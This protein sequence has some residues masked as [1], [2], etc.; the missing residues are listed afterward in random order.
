MLKLIRKLQVSWPGLA[1]AVVLGLGTLTIF[2]YLPSLVKVVGSPS[3]NI[4]PSQALVLGAQLATS[5]GG[6]L[7]PVS[8]DPA[9]IPFNVIQ[10]QTASLVAA[11]LAEAGLIEKPGLLKTYMRYKG[12]DVLIETGYFELSTTQ[13]IPEIALELTDAMPAEIRVRLWP[14]WRIE[15]IAAALSQRTYINVNAEVF[16]AYAQMATTQ[17]GKYAFVEYLPP[18]G[19]VE[20]LLRPD[21]YIFQPRATTI[22]VFEQLFTTADR[23]LEHLRQEA[24]GNGNSWYEILTLA[25]IVER[26]TIHDDEGALIAGVFLRRL[27][28]GM[29]LSADPTTQY[30]IARPGDWWPRLTFDPRQVEHPYNTYTILGMP[31][32]PICSPGEAAIRSV[33]NAA[34]TEYL[35]FRAS[36]DDS[37]RHNFSYTYE[38][39][40]ANACDY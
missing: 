21:T 1:L 24:V 32:G 29:P 30:A 22:D 28:L 33:I 4:P 35:Y 20:G 17:P 36:C 25:S 9:I 38:Q 27:Q 31:P 34:E 16:L 13:T 39:H 11:N 40:L 23:Q 15:Q 19:T 12:L 37:N 6:L 3:H 2:R 7:S 5:I 8:S 26:E 14:G 18:G 10:G